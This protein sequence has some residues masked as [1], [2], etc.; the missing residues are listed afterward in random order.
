M[1]NEEIL[2]RT[3]ARFTSPASVVRSA[4][5]RRTPP[6]T[7][8]GSSSSVVCDEPCMRPLP[9]SAATTES[10]SPIP[11][12]NIQASKFTSSVKLNPFNGSRSMTSNT[13]GTYSPK[14]IKN[15]YS[16]DS[17]SRGTY[18][19]PKCIKNRY[20]PD[21]NSRGT[22]SLPKCIKN[23]YSPDSNSSCLLYTSPS[24]RD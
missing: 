10:Y 20:S 18:S 24:P 19:L 13:S 1:I 8:P 3:G 16:P 17:N 5:V 11:E 22:Y 6:F 7:T 21:S 15:R 2:G 4:S 12:V 9:P 23:R 14:C